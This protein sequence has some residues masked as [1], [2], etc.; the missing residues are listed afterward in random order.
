MLE[1]T[2]K[3]LPRLHFQF[4]GEGEANFARVVV[5]V[6]SDMALTVSESHLGG[7]GLTSSV[8][9]FGLQK[10]SAVNRTVYQRGTSEETIASTA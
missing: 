2:S 7:A 6:R 8:I 10:G 9:E 4:S 3:E 1:V 5:V